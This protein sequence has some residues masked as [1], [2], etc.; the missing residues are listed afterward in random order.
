MKVVEAVDRA[1]QRVSPSFATAGAASP[2]RFGAILL[3]V[4][5][6]GLKIRQIDRR[7]ARAPGIASDH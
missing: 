2:C 6:L 3:F 4:V 1:G 5:A 7:G